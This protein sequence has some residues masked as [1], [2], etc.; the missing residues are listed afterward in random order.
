MPYQNQVQLFCFYGNGIG[1]REMALLADRF[2]WYVA[3]RDVNEEG[4]GV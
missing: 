3:G 1:L 2:D 4:G